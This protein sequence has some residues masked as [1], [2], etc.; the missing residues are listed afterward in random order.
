LSLLQGELGLDSMPLTCLP[1]RYLQFTDHTSAVPWLVFLPVQ[2]SLLKGLEMAELV[3]L[4]ER[5]KRD[6][7]VSTARPSVQYIQG[8]V[9]GYRKTSTGRRRCMTG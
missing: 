2:G 6:I 4:R 5:K 7:Q 9:R 1:S 8:W 3:I